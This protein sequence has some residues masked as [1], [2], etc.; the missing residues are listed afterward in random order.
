M[1]GY[2]PRITLARQDLASAALVGLV[3]ATQFVEPVSM[4]VV[5]PSASIRKGPTARSEQVDQLLFGEV[6]DRL[7]SV[8]GHAWG[9]ARRDGYVGW[10]DEACLSAELATPTHRVSAIRTFAFC[11]PSI[12]SAFSRPLSLNALVTVVEERENL[13]LAAD[14]GW[15][16]RSHLT[17]VGIF[18]DDPADVAERYLGAPYL[19][20]GR[21]SLGLDCSGL[22]QQ[23]LYACGRACPR[24]TDMQAALGEPTAADDLRRNDLVFWRGHVGMML[25]GDRLIHANGHYMA[26]V[27]EPLA[28][29]VERIETAGGGPPTAFC[30]P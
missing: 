1:T 10:V 6:F 29:A 21:D 25:N 9:Q 8:D 11:E 2:D 30:R 23:A 24:D 14:I 12:K 20:G 3:R 4:R 7:E 19:W 16:T 28:Q 22:V 5:Q 17:P 13:V 18:E 26:V 15:I 27:I